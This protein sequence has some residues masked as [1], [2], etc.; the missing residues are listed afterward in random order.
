MEAKVNS[1]L[2]TELKVRKLK[3]MDEIILLRK[4]L[5]LNKINFF[6]A[7]GKLLEIYNE[8]LT[9]IPKAKK[10]ADNSYFFNLIVYIREIENRV[11]VNSTELS[12]QLNIFIRC[13]EDE[14][15]KENWFKK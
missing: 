11:I 8:V 15:K 12:S 4:N 14:A 13:I 2:I 9:N 7:K 3:L 5:N 10:E 6:D 1:E